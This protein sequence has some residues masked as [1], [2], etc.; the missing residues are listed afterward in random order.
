MSTPYSEIFELF[1]F[2]IQDYNIDEIYNTSEADFETYVTNFLLKAIPE[3]SN[4]QNDLTNRDDTTKVFNVTL[5]LAEKN[6]LANL[7]TLFWLVKE[8]NNILEM[9]NFLISGDFKAFSSANNLKE[10]RMWYET[11]SSDVDRQ[12]KNYGYNNNDWTTFFEGT[13]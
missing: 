8:I 10:K 4:C 2:N 1:L 5:S 7:M 9:R 11:L 12:I 6:I 3:F 13:S